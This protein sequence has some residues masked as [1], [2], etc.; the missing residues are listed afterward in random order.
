MGRAVIVN[1]RGRRTGRV[2][3]VG[4]AS[5]VGPPLESAAQK[6][7]FE[8]LRTVACPQHPG[9]TL[10]DFAYAVP[11]GTMLAGSA[12]Q[13]AR[14]MTFLK[15]Q[16]LKPGVSDVC[17]ALPVGRWHGMYLEMKRDRKAPVT[18]D[19]KEWLALMALVGYYA[20]VAPGLDSAIEHTTTFMRG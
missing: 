7:Y 11:N 18:A 12:E 15:A 16:G 6:A 1:R 9:K 13:R 17:I 8:Y 14:Y 20:E 5:A 4:V 10:W 3:P 2:R 19:Q